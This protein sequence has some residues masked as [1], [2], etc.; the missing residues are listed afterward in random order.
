MNV[1]KPQLFWHIFLTLDPLVRRRLF[2]LVFLICE[3]LNSNPSVF[4]MHVV[5]IFIDLSTDC[6][7]GYLIFYLSFIY[8]SGH[9]SL[10]TNQPQNA[11]RARQ[12][13]LTKFLASS[14]ILV[15]RKKLNLP[16]SVSIV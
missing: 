8:S 1:L 14:F 11:R 5:G 7:S 10:S 3:I 9:P 13:I 16:A 15:Y 2:Y 4:S 12:S 6:L